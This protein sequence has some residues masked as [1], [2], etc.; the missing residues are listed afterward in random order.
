MFN[1]DAT[2]LLKNIFN[3]WLVEYTDAELTDMESRLYII[4]QHLNF[5]KTA[6]MDSSPS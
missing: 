4:I 3:L 6:Y 5:H 1:T 2:I